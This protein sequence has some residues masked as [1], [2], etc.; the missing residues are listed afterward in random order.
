MSLMERNVTGYIIHFLS[1]GLGSFS[2]ESER[3]IA[4]S[5]KKGNLN[6]YQVL[7]GI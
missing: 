7:F 5:G 6:D 3:V 1:Q 2:L 4:T